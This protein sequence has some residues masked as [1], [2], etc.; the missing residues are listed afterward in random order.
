MHSDVQ[1][2]VSLLHRPKEA[3]IL[4]KNRQLDKKDGG[5]IYDHG[6]V[7]P[8]ESTVSAISDL[9]SLQNTSYIE[10]LEE[11]LELNI[12]DMDTNT[13]PSCQARWNRLTDLPYLLPSAG[14]KA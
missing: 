11:R 7:D 1:K 9:P 4:K 14:S 10:H 6:D 5:I 3:K 8:L 13:I 12:P 2:F